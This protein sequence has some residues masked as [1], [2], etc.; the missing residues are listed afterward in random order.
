MHA[1]RQLIGRAG[2]TATELGL[3]FGLA[4]QIRWFARQRAGPGDAG[5]GPP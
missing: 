3:L 5:A 4:R 1:L 2:P